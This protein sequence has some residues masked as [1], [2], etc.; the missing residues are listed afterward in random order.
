M[1]SATKCGGSEGSS[2]RM[3]EHLA[4][5][6]KKVKVSY[7]WS[8]VF[9]RDWGLEGRRGLSV[10]VVPVDRVAREKDTRAPT[11]KGTDRKEHLS[12]EGLPCLKLD[13]T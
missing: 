12:F 9:R 13:K 10:S 5:D 7:D 2:L 8:G 6:C 1:L 11:T 3:T 4:Y